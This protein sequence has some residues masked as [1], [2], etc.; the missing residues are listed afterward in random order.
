MKFKKK[1]LSAILASTLVLGAVG[2]GESGGHSSVTFWYYGD[3]ETLNVYAEMVDAFNET[4]GKEKNIVVNGIPKPSQGY[5]GVVQQALSGH[6]GPDVVLVWDRYFKQWTSLNFFENLDKYMANST[7]DLSDISE[8]TVS[9]YRYNIENNTSNT[10]DSLYSLPVESSPTALYYNRSA[11][12][13]VGVTVISVDEEDLEAFNAGTKADNTGKLKSE[14]GITAEIPAQGYYRSLY[15]YT[16]GNTWVKPVTSETLVFN[17]RIAMNWDEI[18]DLSMLLTQ[19]YNSSAPTEYGYY[20]EWWFNYGWSVGGDCIEDKTGRGDWTF[21]LGDE[22]PNYKALSDCIVGSTAYKAGEIVGYID[23]LNAAQT[24]ISDE[25]RNLVS[26][27]K[28]M[29]L[30][31]IREA[32]TRFVMLGQKKEYGGLAITPE[33]DLLSTTSKM[34]YFYYGKVAMMVEQSLYLSGA[35]EMIRDFAWDVAPLPIYKEYAY[36]RA[37]DGT[38]SAEILREGIPAAHSSA[39]SLSV[40]S[41]SSKKDASFTFIEWMSGVEGQKIRAKY[42]F[43]PNQTSLGETFIA[44]NPEPKNVAAFL[45]ALDYEMPGDWWYMPDKSWT[46]EWAKALNTRVRNGTMTLDNFF[47]YYIDVANKALN[48]YKS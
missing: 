5:V 23:K 4:V 40:W 3:T 19:T 46:D 26:Q 12:E 2:C 39:S 28:L 45:D 48:R 42:G 15:P 30:P 43:V 22:S 33:P 31:S 29:E 1:A 21:T 32:F 27:G 10:G 8:T 7:L 37:A 20:T 16:E 11:F 24:G 13:Q 18:E 25:V 6:S 36:R 41:G 47:S 35:S 9:R 17:N 14:Y 34:G 44:D 38:V